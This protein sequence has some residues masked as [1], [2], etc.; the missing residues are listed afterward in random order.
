[1]N[2]SY[3]AV[4]FSVRPEHVEG[5]T[6]IHTALLKSKLVLEL[7]RRTQHVIITATIL[8]KGT[9]CKQEI[10]VALK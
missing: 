2:G 4:D 5:R 7:T 3:A 6:R 8:L 10:F 1:M 9:I